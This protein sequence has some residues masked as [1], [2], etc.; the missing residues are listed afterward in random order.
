MISAW[1]IEH[2]EISKGVPKGLINAAAGKRV[3][4]AAE[5]LKAHSE[6]RFAAS[7]ARPPKQYQNQGL[8]QHHLLD[9]TR[10]SGG[11]ARAQSRLSQPEGKGNIG[12]IGAKPGQKKARFVP[13]HFGPIGNPP[14]RK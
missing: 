12:V 4:Y 13:R 8:P 2:T 3:G 11:R 10:S 14:E 7:I 9:S 1:G 6:G 5:R